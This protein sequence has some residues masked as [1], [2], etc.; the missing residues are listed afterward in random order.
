MRL[1]IPKLTISVEY[2]LRAC[3]Y[4]EIQNP[5]KNNEISY[6]RSIHSG[7]FYPRFHIYPIKK[8]MAANEISLDL[9]LDAKQ[10]SYEGAAAHSGEYDGPIVIRES[11][12]IK[13]ISDEFISQDS[14][15]LKQPIGFSQKKS[16]W[17]KIKDYLK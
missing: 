16:L 5:H 10:P 12:R 3:G 15:R 11:E 7:N 1:I 9:H 13:R 8:E 2:F 4:I 6:A 14:G 17:R